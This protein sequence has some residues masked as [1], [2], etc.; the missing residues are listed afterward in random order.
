[1]PAPSPEQIAEVIDRLQD[2]IAR[3]MPEPMAH[4]SEDHHRYL[5]DLFYHGGSDAILTTDVALTHLREFARN[6]T[7]DNAAAWRT[8]TARN[9]I[10][11]TTYRE[12]ARQ[13]RTETAAVDA[14]TTNIVNME[15]AANARRQRRRNTTLHVE[16][17]ADMVE[18]QSTVLIGIGL[19]EQHRAGRVWYD[20]FYKRHFTD[21][22]GTDDGAVIGVVPIDD[23]F[24]RRVQVWLMSIEARLARQS[25]SNVH[26]IVL[27]FAERDERNAPRDWLKAQVWDGAQ[28]LH[29]LLTRGFGSADTNFNTEAGRCWF[30]SMVA[31]IMRPGSKV[32]TMPVL[33]GGQGLF[34]SS[35]LRLIGDDW[36]KAS[37]SSVDSKDFLQELHGVIV[38][39]IPELHS[40]ISSR[41][42]AAMIKAKLSIEEDHFRLSYGRLVQTFKRTA[43]WVGTTNNRDWHTDDTGGRRFWPVHVG[44]IDMDWLRGNRAQL[45][46]EALAYWAARLDALDATASASEREALDRSDDEVIT[47]GKWWN[48]PAAEQEELIEAET[49]VHP[50]HETVSTRLNHELIAGRLYTGDQGQ[51]IEPWDGSLGEA[52]VWG[53]TLTVTRIAVQWLGLSTAEIGRGSAAGKTIG[54][55]MRALGWDIKQVRLP[56]HGERAKVYV[57]SPN[58]LQADVLGRV[59]PPQENDEPY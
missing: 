7:G 44:D 10:N 24:V 21:W 32:D 57:L 25:E 33:I 23:S 26:S 13:R 28:R 55:I 42:G 35:A 36:Y 49:F 52:A 9:R 40:I 59:T 31:R 29:E 41:H 6:L 8:Q 47:L 54:A 2:A 58:R 22:Y 56:P 18:T 5:V 1:M 3:G 27:T 37:S 4:L 50:W 20:S 12:A 38:M 16:S 30:I 53:N 11:F 46:A 17:P 43:V 19:L 48:V 15:Q 39:E 34:K 14:E 45:F 51:T